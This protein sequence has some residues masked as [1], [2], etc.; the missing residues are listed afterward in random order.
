M[1]VRLKE[2][3]TRFNNLKIFILIFLTLI[4]P[5]NINAQLK[6]GVP[7]LTNNLNNLEISSVSEYVVFDD[8]LRPLIKF[9]SNGEVSSDLAESWTIDYS[10]TRFIFTLKKNQYFSDGSIINVGDVL[11]S[12]NR[13]MVSPG[14][15]HGDGPKIKSIQKIDE[16]K[17]EIVLTEPNPFFLTELSSPEYRIVKKSSSSYNVTSGPYYIVKDKIKNVVQLALN[18]NYVFDRD[19]R[20]KNV[21]YHSYDP[22]KPLM[23]QSLTAL[24]LIWPKSTI[25]LS[26]IK[27]IEINGFYIHK[28]NMGFSYWLSV[29][30]NLLSYSERLSIK[31]CLDNVLSKSNFFNENNLSRSQQL[32]LPY[33][34]GRLTQEEIKTIDSKFV[35]NNPTIIN[36]KTVSILLPKGIHSQLLELIKSA[37]P[38]SK[39]S[40][41]SNFSE[42]ST[43]IQKKEYDIALL[44]NDLSS[45]D[46]RSSI[47]VTFN[48]SRPLVFLD[49]KNKDYELM[50]KNINIE[51]NSSV[52]NSEIKKLGES[53]LKDV[54]IYPLYYDYGYVFVKKGLDLSGLNQFSAETFSWKIK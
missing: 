4:L 2:F 34:P 18:K 37:L 43:M 5:M 40:Y 13:L 41:Y 44:N 42:Y 51:Q 12:I 32:F 35:S 7:N 28:F 47:I 26:E 16:H 6:I 49:S 52:R 8:L 11:Y 9:N 14:I 17:F 48:K 20:F 45:V 38:S 1:V 36:N 30:P 39:I 31:N 27:E 23:A 50:L 15:V 46:L 3:L 10:H 22:S 24:D 53:L 21:E 19:V 25:N 33:G 54:I 29:N